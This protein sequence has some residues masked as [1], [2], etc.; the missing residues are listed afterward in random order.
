[1]I[2]PFAVT[3]NHQINNFSNLIDFHWLKKN[4]IKNISRVKKFCKKNRPRL[5]HRSAQSEPVNQNYD[6]EEQIIGTQEKPQ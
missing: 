2:A 3:R 6:R 1:M 5:Q 4:S